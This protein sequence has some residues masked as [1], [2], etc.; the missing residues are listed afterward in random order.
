MTICLQ[1]LTGK[2]DDVKSESSEPF[3]AVYLSFAIV[4]ITLSFQDGT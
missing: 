2:T 1:L 3:H 4:F